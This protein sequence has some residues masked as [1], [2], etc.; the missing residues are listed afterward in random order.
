MAKVA[1]VFKVQLS[2]EP[3]ILNPAHAAVFSYQLSRMEWNAMPTSRNARG[4]D[5]IAY[6]CDCSRVISVQVR[7][8]S[9]KAPVPLG[10][11]LNKAMGDFW[12]IVNEVDK[13]PQLYVLL[14]HEV[15]ALAHR[16]EKDGR[17]TF[18][19][20]PPRPAL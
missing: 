19:L 1:Q 6:T 8:L 10:T 11:S 5:I 4:V 3:F 9:K 15:R 7:T 20:Q 17:V 13:E 2:W 16:G 18:W 14:P 12:V